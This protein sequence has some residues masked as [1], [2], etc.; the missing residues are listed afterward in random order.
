MGSQSGCRG[1]RAITSPAVNTRLLGGLLEWRA[2]SCPRCIHRGLS[3]R[4]RLTARRG[5][6][7]HRAKGRPTRPMRRATAPIQRPPDAMRAADAMHCR[8]PDRHVPSRRRCV[9]RSSF[10][11]APTRAWREADWLASPRPIKSGTRQQHAACPTSP[12]SGR[13]NSQWA[14]CAQKNRFLGT[15][16]N[17]RAEC[18]KIYAVELQV[19]CWPGLAALPSPN[20]MAV[21]CGDPATRRQAVRCLL[22]TREERGPVLVLT[23]RETMAVAGMSMPPC[24][25]NNRR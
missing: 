21:V 22:A 6:D 24:H 12:T 5:T 13:R 15:V 11:A 17:R 19:F 10:V 9:A 18:P 25:P 8:R 2:V 3:I 7:A 23:I 1:N 14:G 20:H 16:R 4:W